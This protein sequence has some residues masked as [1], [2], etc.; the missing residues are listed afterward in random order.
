MIHA[1]DPLGRA[2]CGAAVVKGATVTEVRYSDLCRPCLR[3]V[4]ALCRR[5]TGQQP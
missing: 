2:W 1:Y 4:T 3:E 5:L